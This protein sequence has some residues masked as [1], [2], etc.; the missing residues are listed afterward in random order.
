MDVEKA[1]KDDFDDDEL[2]DPKS[3]WEKITDTLSSNCFSIKLNLL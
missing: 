1:Q 2:V 3:C